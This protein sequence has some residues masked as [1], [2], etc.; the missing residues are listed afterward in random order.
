MYAKIR[1][2]LNRCNNKNI[3]VLCS[4]CECVLF[5]PCSD[6]ASFCKKCTSEGAG[7]CDRGSCK[8]GYFLNPVSFKCESTL[9]IVWCQLSKYAVVK[10]CFSVWQNWLVLSERELTFT[11]AICHR[12]S[13]CL[14][15]VTFM[16]PTQPVE[17]FG[18]VSMPLVPLPSGNIHVKFLRRSCQGN[19][20]IGVVK[21]KRG[22]QI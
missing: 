1:S 17:N 6:C 16:R 8:E 9:Y 20:S 21:R 18:N 14:S 7:K 10:L 15:S 12:P 13:V 22:S 5:T 2:R 19:P 11:F 4:L 3:S